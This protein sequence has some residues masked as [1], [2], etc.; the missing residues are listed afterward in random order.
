MIL[1]KEIVDPV[2]VGG[3]GGARVVVLVV[4]WTVV[5]GGAWVVVVVDGG[6]TGPDDGSPIEKP[7]SVT[8]LPNGALIIKLTITKYESHFRLYIW[9]WQKLKIGCLY[10][11]VTI[12]LAI[13]QSM[14]TF[15]NAKVIAFESIN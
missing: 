11:L 2:V 14:A 9:F 3:G 4:D 5:G 13:L 7:I 12:I 1:L 6:L 8:I 15:E 10:S